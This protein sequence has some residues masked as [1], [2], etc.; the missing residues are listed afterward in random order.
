MLIPGVCGE[1]LFD[2]WLPT[3]VPKTEGARSDRVEFR[4]LRLLCSGAP[5]VVLWLGGRFFG[6]YRQNVSSAHQGVTRGVSAA[7]KALGG[8]KK[9]EGGGG[10]RNCSAQEGATQIQKVKETQL[11]LVSNSEVVQ[12]EARLLVCV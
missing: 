7:A 12:P 2:C 4:I 10:S 5:Q 8:N 3:H 1:V 9:K 11:R 6:E